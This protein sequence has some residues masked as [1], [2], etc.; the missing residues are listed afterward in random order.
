MAGYFI[1]CRKSSEAEDR[2]VL[3][4]ESQVH[5]LQDTAARLG[6]PV[7][8]VLTEAMSAKAPG[9]PVFNQ[10]MQRIYNGEADGILCWKLDRLARNPVDGGSIIWTIKQHGIHVVT[11]SQ[12]FGHGED[13][14]ILMY[15]EFGMA[16]KYVDDLSRNVKRGLKTKI[17]KGGYPGVAPMGYLNYT[18]PLTH[19]KRIVKD[20]DRF[21]LVRRI[22]DLMLTGLYT[23]P[24]ILELA[25]QRWG[26]RTRKTRRTG[27]CPLARSSIYKILSNPFYYGHFEAPRNSGDWHKG[28]HEPMVTQAEYDRVQHLLRRKGTPRP[29]V[30]RNFPFTGL[31]RCGECGAMITAEE[32]CQIR[33]GQCRHKFSSLH[34]DDCPRCRARIEKMTNSPRRRYTYY[35]CSRGKSSGCRQGS[36]TGVDLAR[37][38]DSFLARIT[39]SHE[40]KEWAL[41]YLHVLHEADRRNHANDTEAIRKALETCTL[42]L[43]N[44]IKLKTSPENTLGD[45]LTDEEYAHQRSELIQ[46]KHRLE[47]ALGD[48]GTKANQSLQQATEVFETAA[49]ARARFAEGN[50][51]VQKEILT[52]IGSN[53]TL[54][55]KILTIEAAKPFRIIED[56]LA[57]RLPEMDP[58]EPRTTGARKGLRAVPHSLRLRWLGDL[59]SNQDTGL[60]RPMSYH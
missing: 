15:I 23:P 13:N 22:W 41:K 12:T 20:P 5:E 16:Q 2:Q 60:Q 1:Y 26:F 31:I 40:F 11:P 52:T 56:G 34:R 36:L 53:H 37:Q 17:E 29:S 46:E 19:D 38:I 6:L 59:D 45:L 10:M 7:T 33:C 44:L 28:N 57:G 14:V 54:T 48:T 43:E 25:N 4:I 47:S 58:L 49:T 8:E 21:S 32:K 18:D 3:S 24:Q 30:H 39:I 9:R 35:H 42:R 51:Q 55:G 27:G 50:P